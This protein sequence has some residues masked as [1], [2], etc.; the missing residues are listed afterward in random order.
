MFGTTSNATDSKGL[1]GNSFRRKLEEHLENAM[2]NQDEDGGSSDSTPTSPEGGGAGFMGLT[3]GF[4]KEHEAKERKKGRK[5]KKK[6][7]KEVK[8]LL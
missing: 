5:K 6:K 1:G 4:L 3:A 7:K 8:A 2:D